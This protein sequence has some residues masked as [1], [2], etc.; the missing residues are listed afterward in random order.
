MCEISISELE[1]NILLEKQKH[2]ILDQKIKKLKEEVM[3]I[4]LNLEE[5]RKLILNY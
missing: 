4:H 5:K 3:I 1:T 2:V